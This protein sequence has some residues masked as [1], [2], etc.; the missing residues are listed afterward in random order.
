MPARVPNM[1]EVLALRALVN[2]ISPQ[3]LVL[4]LFINDAI[5]AETDEAA[6]YTEASGFG[7]EAIKLR[8]SL[9]RFVEGQASA[10]SYPLQSFRFTGAIGNIY[11]FY[12]TQVVS[13]SLVCAERFTDGPY[14][15]QNAND[16]IEVL[17][18]IAME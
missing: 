10:A 13:G 12:L 9:W 15:I 8:G 4:R 17:V 14:D 1:G 7:Y 18:T 11:G 6:T 16:K 3:N 2:N 5:P